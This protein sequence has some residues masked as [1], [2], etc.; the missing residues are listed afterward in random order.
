MEIKKRGFIKMICS[1]L[2]IAIAVIFMA[3][4]GV[5]STIPCAIAIAVGFTIG[6]KTGNFIADRFYGD[7]RSNSEWI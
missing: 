5:T 2:G 3:L 4:I 6:K 1:I 7:A